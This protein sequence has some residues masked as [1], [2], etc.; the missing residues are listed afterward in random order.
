V[1]A[2]VFHKGD[3]E[4]HVAHFDATFLNLELKE[5]SFIEVPE[6]LEKLIEEDGLWYCP[7]TQRMTENVM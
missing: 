6:G 2:F 4:S 1:I 5:E 7:S 3:W